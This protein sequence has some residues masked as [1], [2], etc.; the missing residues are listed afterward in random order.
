MSISETPTPC[1]RC[2]CPDPSLH[3]PRPS[4]RPDPSLHKSN[5]CPAATGP[6]DIDIDE[7]DVKKAI[8]ILNVPELNREEVKKGVWLHIQ[9]RFTKVKNAIRECASRF[10][11]D[12]SYSPNPGEFIKAHP[13]ISG[14]VAGIVI[15]LII[16]YTPA[17][18][19]LAGFGALGP[20]KG[21]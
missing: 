7:A 9:S 19:S 3:P 2:R 18:L 16:Y 4:P 14:I 8:E 6:L 13:I 12:P 1:P 20:V 15:A 17:L 10:D 5:G 11:Y 21:K